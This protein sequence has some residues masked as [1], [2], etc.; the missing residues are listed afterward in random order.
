MN[1]AENDVIFQAVTFGEGAV[2]ISYMEQRDFEGPINEMRTLVVPGELV[3][4][5]LN[6]V[7]DALQQLLDRALLL[8]RKPPERMRHAR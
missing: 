5:E 2:E 7:Q 4:D 3:A 8:R 1:G 6:E